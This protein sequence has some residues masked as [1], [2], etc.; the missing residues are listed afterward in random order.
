MI[1][2][3]NTVIPS[4]LSG[5][6][7][8]VRWTDPGD[9]TNTSL[10]YGEVR[11]VIYPTD[12]KSVTKRFVEYS[13]EIQHKDGSGPGT[14]VTY[15]NCLQMGLF[16]TVAD[17]F[18]YTLRADKQ[19]R[20]GTSLGVGAKVAVLFLNGDITKGLI[21][22]ALRDTGTDKDGSGYEGR[23]KKE[24]GHNLFFEFNGAQ[25]TIDKDGQLQVRYR[26][27]T[28][29]DGT[30]ADHTNADAEGSTIVFN[31]DG[32][33]KLYTK[34]EK[35]FIHLNNKDKKLDILADEEWHVKVNKKLAIE[36]GDDVTIQGDKTCTVEMSDKVYVRSAGVHVGSA[37]DAWLL[38]ETY[39]RAESQMFSS[40]ATAM[41]TLQGLISVAASSIQAAGIANAVPVT[42][43]AGAAPGFA[44]AA[45]AL[46]SAAPIFS[47][48]AAS[49]RLFEAAA[50]TYLSTKNKND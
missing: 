47:Q 29:V 45:V 7:Q 25:V 33:I 2:S 24:D 39:R 20:G 27:A 6:E 28:K 3:D 40:I 10:R 38:A 31:K 9:Q 8:G 19:Q 41:T 46:N 43:G 42:G 14:S 16:G 15:P 23:D 32:D 1:L 49:V 18:Q 50:A 30:L 21:I 44:A 22:G 34:D 4:Y 26:G 5:S 11:E 17:S 13:V 37:T 35:Q 12:A 36:A 48:M